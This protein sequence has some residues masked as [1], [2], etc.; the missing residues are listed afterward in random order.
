MFRLR[1]QHRRPQV[2]EQ[3][4]IVGTVVCA[5]GTGTGVIYAENVGYTPGTRCGQI[6]NKQMYDYCAS[7]SNASGRGLK[8]DICSR[9]GDSGGP[10]WSQAEG[11]AYGILSGGPSRSGACNM[12]HPDEFGVY[13]PLSEDLADASAKTGITMSLI[14]TSNGVGRKVILQE[15]RWPLLVSAPIFERCE[16]QSS[17][18]SPAARPINPL[19]ASPYTADSWS[20]ANRF[21]YTAI[22]PCW[23][24]VSSADG[25]S[26]RTVDPSKIQK[27]AEVQMLRSAVDGMMPKLTLGKVI[28]VSSLSSCP[29]MIPTLPTRVR[30]SRVRT[31]SSR[32]TT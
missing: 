3:H 23:V 8:V 21:S 9:P 10:L 19:A 27:P 18:S 14:T 1:F 13:S 11:Q 16:A 4:L 24:M 25:I 12:S 22:S 26:T 7:C 31:C 5:T 17:P 6:Q 29:R 2:L 20:L 30:M 28:S 32:T 15:G